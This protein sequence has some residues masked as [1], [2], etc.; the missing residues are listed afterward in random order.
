MY[1]NLSNLRYKYLFIANLKY[2]Y[3]TISLYLENY[4]Y[5]TFIILDI[6]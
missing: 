3:L 6:K 1:N 2:T 4:Y 5:F